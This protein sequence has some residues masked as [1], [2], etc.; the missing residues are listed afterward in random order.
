MKHV[1]K[2][3]ILA[4]A[5]V[6]AMSVQAAD[7][8]RLGSCA[9]YKDR[10]QATEEAKMRFGKLAGACEGVYDIDGNL[11]VRAEMVIRKIHNGTVTL[12]LPASDETVEVT[13]NMDNSAYLDGRKRRFR[14]LSR[15]DEVELYV[16]M[17]RFFEER[18]DE[19]GVATD[20]DVMM[21]SA[22][23]VSALPTTAS[24]LPLFGLI[25]GLLLSVGGLMRLRRR[26]G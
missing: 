25:S 8:V 7:P 12:Y 11:Y 22:A 18:Y 21:T 13:P 9:D 20:D 24:S 26:R 6:G 3:L 10:Y 19:I 4:T 16:S 23:A 5:V 14:D 15:G 2:P 1:L 17:D